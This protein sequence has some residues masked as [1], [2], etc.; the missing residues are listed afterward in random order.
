[1][2]QCKKPRIVITLL[3]LG[4]ALTCGCE[5]DFIDEQALESFASFVTGVVTAVVDETIRP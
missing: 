1:M 2:T 3:I 4:A 5:T